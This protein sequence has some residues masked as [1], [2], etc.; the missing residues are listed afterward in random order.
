M[1]LEEDWEDLEQVS[2]MVDD[3]LDLEEILQNLREQSMLEVQA[4][5]EKL[6]KPMPYKTI[7]KKRSIQD[8][9]KAEANRNLGYNGMSDRTKRFHEKNQRDR[10]EAAEASRKTFDSLLN[11]YS[12]IL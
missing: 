9:K 7:M 3:D 5:V 12:T 1:E 6:L 2:G 8:W 10:A 11:P 4:E